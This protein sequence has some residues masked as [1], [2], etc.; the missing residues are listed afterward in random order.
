MQLLIRFCTVPLKTSLEKHLV[1]KTKY[2]RTECIHFLLKFDPEFLKPIKFT[3][4]FKSWT[5]PSNFPLSNERHKRK[6]SAPPLS[7]RKVRCPWW[8]KGS[9]RRFKSAPRDTL[10]KQTAR[11]HTQLL[12]RPEQG[13]IS[14]HNR[15]LKIICH[16]HSVYEIR[17]VHRLWHVLDFLS[18]IFLSSKFKTLCW[19]YLF[20]NEQNDAHVCAC[21]GR[22]SPRLGGNAQQGVTAWEFSENGP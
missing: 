21:R 6:H 13:G 14:A 8:R 4:L 5:S 19:V 9:M 15:L 11:K 16:R 22:G 17:K 20:W 18:S 7:Q 1:C 3:W 12:I 10:R 2:L